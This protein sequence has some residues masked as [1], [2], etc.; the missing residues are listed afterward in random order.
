[1][2]IIFI[3]TG[4]FAIPILEKLINNSYPITAVI[5]APDK[6]AGR[7]NEL[8]SSP[9]K[10][11]ALKHKLTVLQPGKISDTESE[12]RNLLPDLIVTADY[13]Q[14]IPQGI[15]EIPKSG[16]L[17]LHPS[18]LPKYRGPSPIQT[19]ILNGDGKTGLTI[20]LMDA[21]M[22][23]GPI[24]AQEETVIRN[25]DNSQTLEKRLSEQAAELLIKTLPLYLDNK[26]KP[27]PQSESQASY[28]KIL[29]RQD[30]QIDLNQTAEQ[31]Q[32]MVR[33]FY[34]WPGAWLM[35]NGQRVKILKAEA[36][37]QKTEA[38]LKAKKGYLLLEMVQPAGKKPMT[39]QEFARGH[40]T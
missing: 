37:N 23:H 30:G 24:V 4:E 40:L 17:N 38:S 21:K 7:R 29:T 18:L 34:P 27:R 36:I 14:I 12:I 35:I 26:I 5:T 15:L 32:R 8:T 33:A 9:V 10:K 31:I 6:P 39:G 3:G 13:G 20:I 19:A 16:C 11:V 28:T 25:D 1:M 2:N 22:D